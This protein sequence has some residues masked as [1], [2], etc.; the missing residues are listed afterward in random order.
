MSRSIV[1]AVVVC[2]CGGGPD[3]Y[4]IDGPI[5]DAAGDGTVAGGDG[6]PSIADACATIAMDRCTKLQNCSANDFQVQYGTLEQCLTR[7]ELACTDGLGAPDTGATPAGTIAC[8]AALAAEPCAQFLSPGAPAACVIAGPNSGTCSF[9]AQCSTEFCAIGAHAVCGLCE[10]QPVAGTSCADNDCGESGLVCDTNNNKCAMPA[11][12]NQACNKTIPCAHGT[13]CVGDTNTQNGK[14]ELQ[15]TT[16]G[17]TCD[18]TRKNAPTCNSDDGLTCN[19]STK[20][21]VA[22]PVVA[23]GMACG[24]VN[25]VETACLGGAHC[26]IASGRTSGTCIADAM[27]GGTC[28]TTAG[29]DCTFPA[30]CAWSTSTG[31]TGTCQLPGTG[32]C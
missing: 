10:A 6:G 1:I 29:P 22:R 28:N 17:G 8:G 27:D 14:C 13:S 11:Q 24:L 19:Q 20:K 5:G 18:P 32:G 31:P 7:E 2:A 25:N 26:I 12:V 21:C 9:E 16:M 23:A 30:R 15:V 4:F 3:K